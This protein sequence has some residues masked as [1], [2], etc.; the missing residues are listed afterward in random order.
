[1]KRLWLLC[2]VGVFSLAPVL[3][4]F[5]IYDSGRPVLTRPPYPGKV[6]V[7]AVGSFWEIGVPW[8]PDRSYPVVTVHIDRVGGDAF[9]TLWDGADVPNEYGVE[10]GQVLGMKQG[11]FW[12]RVPNR[13]LKKGCYNLVM[14]RS[15][16]QNLITR[17]YRFCL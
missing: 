16:Q 3:A 14:V 5:T 6:V 15:T 8:Q 4:G 7:R 2:A 11:R 13:A 9:I 17:S 12:Y 10:S 1:M